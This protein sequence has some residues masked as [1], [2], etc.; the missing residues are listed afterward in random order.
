MRLIRFVISNSG[1]EVYINPEN[2]CK[3]GTLSDTYIATTDGKDV[4]VKGTLEEVLN[5]LQHG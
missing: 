3:V 5:T 1:R 2:V 4:E